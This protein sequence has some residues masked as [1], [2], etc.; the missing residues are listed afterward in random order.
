MKSIISSHNKQILIPKNK[1]IKCNFGIK[2]SCPLDNKCLTS[3]LIYQADVKN[4]LDDECKYYVRLSGT[5][6]KER[7]S[8]Q[9]SW[10]N[11]ENSKNSTELPKH[12]WS[13]RENNK[14]P[15]VKSNIVKTVYSKATSSFCKAVYF[16]CLGG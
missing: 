7:C 5:T 15:S 10:F 9:K 2:N 13:L 11:N 3:Q 4:N 6:F 8:N 16:E 14:I 1:Q 12:V